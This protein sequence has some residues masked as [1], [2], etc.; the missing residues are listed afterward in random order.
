MEKLKK[1]QIPF[2][3]VANKVANDERL[4][5]KA[6]G[7]YLY[8]SSKPDGWNF[9]SRRMQL[10]S[11]DGKRSTDSGLNELEECGYL[12]R[13]KTISGRVEYVLYHSIAKVP[14]QHKGLNKP[15]CYN[16]KVLKQHNA[17]TAPV[18]NKESI[19]IKNNSN[20]E[21]TF[22]AENDS[23]SLHLEDV[24]QTYKTKKKIYDH[25]GS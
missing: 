10:D 7:L 16:S 23:P 11:V 12:V 9:S 8:I 17:K 14:K 25:K 18:S 1:E 6:K 3:Q 19:V 2:T 21:S 4:S 13:M 20:K 22:S 24:K 15:K 5:W